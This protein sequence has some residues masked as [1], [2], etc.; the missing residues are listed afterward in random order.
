MATGI[1]ALLYLYPPTTEKVEE[2][3]FTQKWFL[4]TMLMA[5]TLV[6]IILQNKFVKG[7][8]EWDL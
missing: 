4:P 6:G 1:L 7:S 8:K 3:I 2:L 5:P